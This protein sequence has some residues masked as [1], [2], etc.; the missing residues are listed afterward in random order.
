MTNYT[1]S[2]TATGTTATPAGQ[3]SISRRRLGLALALCTLPIPGWS[4]ETAAAK[5]S[6]PLNIPPAQRLNYKIAGK[7]SFFPY[8]ADGALTWQHDGREYTARME[9]E[10]PVIGSR[11]QT[12]QGRIVATGLQPLHFVDRVKNDRT[13]D[14]DYVQNLVR[15]SEPIP[16][17]PLPNGI[18][19]HLSVFMQLGAMISSAPQRYPA[20]TPIHIPA[21]GIYGPETWH[22]V[23]NGE[24][25]IDLPG[26]AQNTV[27]I[28]R[29]QSRDGDPSS[30]VWLAPALGWLPARIRMTQGN[31]DYVDQ[32]WRGN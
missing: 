28:S 15:F 32:L 14:F 11:V 31:G 23:V 30:E 16:P 24:E 1:M 18:Q 21:F 5:T 27:K 4:G 7:V 20:G 13:V 6:T 10:V 25:K 3:P 26:G 17:E 29:P 9:I 19:D 2:P 8:R 12:S 22:L